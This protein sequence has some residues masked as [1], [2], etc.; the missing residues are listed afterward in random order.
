MTITVSPR[1][2]VMG[3]TIEG[4]DLRRLPGDEVM[5][6]IRAAMLDHL[7][8]VFPD[9]ELDADSLLAF[10]RRLGPLEVHVLSEYHLGGHPEVYLLS[11]VGPDGKTTGT[12]PDLGTLVWHSDLSFKA[13]PAA[14]TLLYGRKVPRQGADT[15]YASMYRAYDTLPDGL[16]ARIAGLEAEHDLDFSRRRAG[17]ATAMSEE[18]RA[19]APPVSHPLVRRHPETGRPSLYVGHHCARILGIPEDES[20]ALLGELMGHAAS[21][22]NVYAHRWRQRDLVVWDNR[23]TL[24]RAT[25][26]DTAAERRVM[27]RTVV[28]GEPP[29][30]ANAA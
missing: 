4:V 27:Y 17:V 20:N 5:A 2:A 3:A 25:G 9:Q 13:V 19:S 15:L 23:C 8:V 14:F 18:Q 28:T 7:L 26:F 22:D 21:D 24:H 6:E 10:S 30:A 29:I 12:H 16:K 11:N 1:S